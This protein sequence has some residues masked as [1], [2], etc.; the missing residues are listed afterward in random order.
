MTNSDKHP[1]VP[2]T[3]PLRYSLRAVYL[4]HELLAIQRAAN[5]APN[6]KEP[7]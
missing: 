1:L 3:V 2:E 4:T 7:A 6:R 5:T